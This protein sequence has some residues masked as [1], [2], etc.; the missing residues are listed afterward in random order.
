MYFARALAALSVKYK[1][2]ILNC[3]EVERPRRISPVR[4][5]NCWMR[6]LLNQNVRYSLSFDDCAVLSR[7]QEP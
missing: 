2:S 7:D 3:L 5:R 1:S 6:P 4:V